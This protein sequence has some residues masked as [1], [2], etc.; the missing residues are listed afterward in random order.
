MTD[1]PDRLRIAFFCGA[2][3]PPHLGHRAVAQ[4]VLAAGRS[5]RVLWV[6]S[7]RPPHKNP[8]GMVS[9]DDRLAMTELAAA[10]VPGSFVSDIEKRKQFEPSYTIRVLAALAEEFPEAR[11][12]LLIGSDSLEELHTWYRAR[13]LADRYEVITYPRRPAHDGAVRLPEEFWGAERAETLR[14]SVLNGNFV[15]I[16]STE[17]RNALENGGKCV[18][19]MEEA[20]LSYIRQHGLYGISPQPGGER[21]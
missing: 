7:Y 15:E 3:D 18:H 13:E 20:V 17:L 11:M 4:A 5:D 10:A 6:P 8:A 16:S 14:K 2:F 9:F 19:I 1:R 21:L 12:Q